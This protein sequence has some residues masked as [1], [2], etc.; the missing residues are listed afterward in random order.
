MKTKKE[1]KDRLNKISIE[2]KE[3]L[4]SLIHKIEFLIKKGEITEETLKELQAL[5]VHLMIKREQ[6]FYRL[7]SLLKQG[8]Q[9]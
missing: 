1:E 7:L 2:D 6:Y 3:E 5:I 8:Y 4:Q 9:E